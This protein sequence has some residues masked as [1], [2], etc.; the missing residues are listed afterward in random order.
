VNNTP[1]HSLP[2]DNRIQTIDILRGLLIV[3]MALDH[4]RDFFQLDAFAFSPTDP[5][6]ANVALY[7]TRWI[8]HLCA[9]GFVW[10]SGISAFMHYKK[11]GFAKTSGFLFSRGLILIAFEFTIIKLGWHFNADYS[12]LGLLVIWALGVSM[13]LLALTLWLKQQTVFIIGVVIIACHNLL[14]SVDT[15][16]TGISALVWHVLHQAGD[17]ALTENF[18]VHVLYPIL[19]MYG[20]ICLGY[21]MGSLFTDD[22]KEERVALF[23]RISLLL[24]LAFASIRLLNSY[25]DP[26]PWVFNQYFYRTAFSFLNVTK[27]PMSLDYILITLSVL[28]YLVSKIEMSTL[29]INLPLA[30]FGKV[31]MFFYIAHIF[32]IHTLAMIAAI[33]TYLIK[34]G[35]DASNMNADTVT[36]NYGYALIVVYPVWIGVLVVLYPL[37]KKYRSVKLKYPESL[38][39]FL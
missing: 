10:L 36:A 11:N 31:S 19:P 3:L 37:C 14:D 38:L 34:Q 20:L 23:K 26:N 35:F 30:L 39:K 13:V 4:V 22:N 2:S 24:L 33:I 29:K 6:K 1:S 15:G 16:N 21:G 5:E 12:K 9:P 17:V 25:G 7:I 8:T 27:Y 28:F 32:V 18:T